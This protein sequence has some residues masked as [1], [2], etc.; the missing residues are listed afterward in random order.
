[1]RAGL[2]RHTVE[3]QAASQTADAIGHMTTTWAKEATRKA[4]IDALR[5]AEYLAAQQA[6]R[7]TTHRVRMRYYSG[8]TSA[9]R[10][11]WTEEAKTLDIVAVCPVGQKRRM[12]EVMC[13]EHG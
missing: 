5:G 12:V 1:M 4:Q 2:A 8:L 9:H 13:V 10:L 7:K 6:E 11:Y 3:I